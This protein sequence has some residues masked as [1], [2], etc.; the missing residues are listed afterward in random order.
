MMK[1]AKVTSARQQQAAEEKSQLLRNAE[2][3]EKLKL[4]PLGYRSE[5]LLTVKDVEIIYGDR[6]ICKPVSFEI[7]RGD[8]VALS[9][10]NG[11]GKSSFLKLIAG[12]KI[13]HTGVFT[14]SSGLIISYI[15]QTTDCA[16]GR[17][18]DFAKQNK[19][20]EYG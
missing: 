19:I 5:R 13:G 20:D 17:L 4:F 14:L 10:K 6:K 1:R 16:C 18:C 11:C 7:M 3:C 12:E 9:G 8:R 2:T 15:P